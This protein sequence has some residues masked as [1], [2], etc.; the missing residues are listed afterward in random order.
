M[1]DGAPLPIDPA[2]FDPGTVAADAV[3][4][5]EGTAFLAAA[6]ARGCATAPGVA[7][8]EHQ[9]AP[10]CARFGLPPW[11]TPQAAAISAS[12]GRR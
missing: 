8:V 5:I 1:S 6:A 9:M 12:T 10:V 3:A 4:R 11:R 2:T 7:M